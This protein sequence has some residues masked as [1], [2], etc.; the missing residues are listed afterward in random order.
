LPAAG[1][2]GSFMRFQTVE[3]GHFISQ[4]PKKLEKEYPPIT[5][6]SY[7]RQ[8]AAKIHLIRIGEPIVQFL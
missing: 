5:N 8:Q 3:S 7:C 6:N 2:V 1:Q 4:N